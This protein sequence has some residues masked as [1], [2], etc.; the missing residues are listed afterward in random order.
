MNGFTT[1]YPLRLILNTGVNL[2]LAM[3]LGVAHNP[4]AASDSASPAE[5]LS[6]NACLQ[7]LNDTDE[8]VVTAAFHN[9]IGG[10][11]QLKE[12]IA[13][14]PWGSVNEATQQQLDQLID[15][16]SPFLIV[17]LSKQQAL[18]LDEHRDLIKWILVQSTDKTCN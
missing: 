11:G 10:F 7:Q 14:N 16:L 13:R 9:G 15:E 3:V 17:T 18:V 1:R 2:L 4:V 12:L 6:A 5:K 8:V